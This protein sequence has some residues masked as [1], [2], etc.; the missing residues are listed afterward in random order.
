[1]TDT[2]FGLL[3]KDCSVLLQPFVVSEIAVEGTI[4]SH[5]NRM[6]VLVLSDLHDLYKAQPKSDRITHKLVFY[7]AQIISTP[8]PILRGLAADT[9]R[10]SNGYATEQVLMT[11]TST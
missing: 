4:A 5:P 1:M 3:L 8:S 11:S 6:P 9:E 2:L 7:A 10:R